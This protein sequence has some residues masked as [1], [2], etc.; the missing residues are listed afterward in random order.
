MDP[1]IASNGP[2][3]RA[4]DRY[5]LGTCFGAGCDGVAAHRGGKRVGCINDVADTFGA[6]IIDHTGDAAKSAHAH[7]QRLGQR[8]AGSAGIREHG[9]GPGIRQ[10][11]SQSARLG[12]AA[13]KQDAR[14]V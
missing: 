8:V 11:K 5:Q 9:I 13:E 6:Q 3:R 14:H 10:G 4:L 7:R 12:G 2:P 1:F